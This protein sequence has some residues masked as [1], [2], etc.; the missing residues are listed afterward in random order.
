MRLREWR[1]LSV[2]GAE[3]EAVDDVLHES[4]CYSVAFIYVIRLDLINTMQQTTMTI[5]NDLD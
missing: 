1:L 4:L 2:A 3:L 5:L